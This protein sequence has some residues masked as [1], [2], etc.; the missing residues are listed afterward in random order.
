MAALHVDDTFGWGCDNQ[1]HSRE[2]ARNQ[3]I[4]EHASPVVI[5]NMIWALAT[6]GV[7]AKPEI[8]EVIGDAA[9]ASDTLI[10]T[11]CDT[12]NITDRE[13]SA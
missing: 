8:L 7:R 10:T 4:K 3:G 5:E 1:T 6:A 2:A 13:E 9:C 12:Q 11:Y